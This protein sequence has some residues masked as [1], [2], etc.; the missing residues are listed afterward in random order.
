MFQFE[1]DECS[2]YSSLSRLV[3]IEPSTAVADDPY[4]TRL[5][6]TLHRHANVSRYID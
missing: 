4:E 1:Y 3:V 5:H 2:R 6:L